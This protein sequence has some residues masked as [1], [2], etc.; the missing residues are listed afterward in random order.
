[1]QAKG[2]KNVSHF[3]IRSMLTVK[4]WLSCSR[5]QMLYNTYRCCP[6]LAFTFVGIFLA[7]RH[8][9]VPKAVFKAAKEKKIMLASVKRKYV[10]INPLT[11]YIKEQILLSCFHTFLIKVLGRS[12]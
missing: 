7:F 5:M 12:Y 11:P 2:Y 3:C 6:F 8:R 1:M 10:L 9:H 4:T